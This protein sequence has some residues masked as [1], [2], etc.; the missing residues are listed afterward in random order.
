MNAPKIIL[1]FL[2][3]LF[4]VCASAQDILSDKKSETLVSFPTSLTTPSFSSKNIGVSGPIWKIRQ[5]QFYVTKAD[6]EKV[7][8][9]LKTHMLSYNVNIVDNSKNTLI[10][11]KKTNVSPHFEIGYNI[12]IDYLEA[13][14]L[15]RGFYYTLSVAG[16]VD[17]QNFKTY[18]PLFGALPPSK[19]RRWNPGAK[20]VTNIF[21]GS[22]YALSL[23][24][25]YRHAVDVDKLTSFQL[26]TPD[27]LSDA[28]VASNGTTDCYL[29]PVEAKSITRLSAALPIFA[30]HEVLLRG[31]FPNIQLV[32]TPYYFVTTNDFKKTS[33][34][35]GIG[36]SILPA[37][38][39]K[40]NNIKF[41]SALSLSYNLISSGDKANAR[42]LYV[43]G[44]FSLGVFKRKDV[45]DK[46]D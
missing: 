2:T 4:P 25:S 13:P 18:D 7:C 34:N 3:G 46:P 14:D 16:F 19:Y 39:Y 23:S 5:T 42:F 26:K 27:F 6:G 15:K 29:G 36:L 33:H 44:T 22:H 45:T 41:L 10:F 30:I 28:N 12:A 21:K 11:S 17:Y 9:M 40:Q 32:P 43:S 1:L 8:T 31:P 35:A 20:V 24:G 37:R 38:I